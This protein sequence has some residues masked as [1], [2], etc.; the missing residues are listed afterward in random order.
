MASRIGLL[1][2]VLHVIVKALLTT[3]RCTESLE[4]PSEGG[5]V[6]LDEGRVDVSRPEHAQHPGKEPPHNFGWNRNQKT[7]FFTT[8]E[9][10]V[11]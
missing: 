10:S 5:A 3:S 11:E 9:P 7:L 8:L 6:R 1:R 2:C 4:R